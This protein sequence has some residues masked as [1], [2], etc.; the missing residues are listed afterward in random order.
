MQFKSQAD[1]YEKLAV[2]LEN[3]ENVFDSIVEVIPYDTLL[4]ESRQAPRKLYEIFEKKCILVTGVPA[5]SSFTPEDLIF[6]PRLLSQVVPG[7]G[8]K[9]LEV[10]GKNLSSIGVAVIVLIGNRSLKTCS[11]KLRRLHVTHGPYRHSG[12][13]QSWNS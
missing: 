2:T 3:A 12:I 9:R 4:G 8:W 1:W 11:S 7:S 13:Y 6:G 10:H 5:D